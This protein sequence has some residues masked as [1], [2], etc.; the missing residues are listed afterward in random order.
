M[1]EDGKQEW[2]MERPVK[3]IEGRRKSLLDRPQPELPRINAALE[4]HNDPEDR[5]RARQLLH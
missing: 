1:H 2:K 4:G 5:L 3:K